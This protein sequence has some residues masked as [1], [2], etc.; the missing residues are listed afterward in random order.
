MHY[1]ARAGTESAPAA[2]FFVVLFMAFVVATVHG[3]QLFQSENTRTNETH[4][5]SDTDTGIIARIG[6][7]SISDDHY[8]NE[9]LRFYYR[10][11]Q[12]V[13]L[14]PQVRK[15]VVDSRVER[16]GIVSYAIENNWHERPEAL[17]RK[18]RIERKVKMETFE[19]LFIHNHVTV[20]DQDL[21]TL[22]G[23]LNT[24][25]RASHLFFRSNAMAWSAYYRLQDGE[26]FSDIAREAFQNAALAQNGGD[27]GYF[28]VDDMDIAFENTA[29]QLDIGEISQ[30]VKT[31]RGYSIIKLTDRI[32]TPVLT[33]AQFA[34]ARQ[35]L[36]PM[37]LDQKK[38]LATRNHMQTV[39]GSFAFDHDV[40]SALWNQFNSHRTELSGEVVTGERLLMRMQDRGEAAYLVNQDD[41]TLSA[42]DFWREFYYT[43]SEDRARVSH[44]DQFM[45]LVEGI[46]YRAYALNIVSLHG[47][48]DPDLVEATVQETFYD[49]LLGEFD[50]YVGRQVVIPEDQLQIEFYENRELYMD[51][52]ELNLSEIILTT[53]QEAERAWSELT[54]GT[55]FSDVLRTYTIDRDAVGYNG[56][57]GFISLPHFG[58][59]APSLSELQPGEIAGP[60]QISSHRYLIFFCNGRRESRLTTFEESKERVRAQLHSRGK[61]QLRSNIVDH[62]RS[63]FNAHVYVERMLSLPVEL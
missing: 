37:A 19:R 30:P 35:R 47:E 12:A 48:Y 10:T 55:P 22:F 4:G 2:R 49:Y 58:S 3:C 1:A 33:E 32:T 38:E 23:R 40:I 57:L 39:I 20:S 14:N 50:E 62:I 25:L 15:T 61:R 59:M 11:G 31:S 46:A 26:R 9:L 8:R 34:E 54:S 5:F 24:S 56:E 45:Q 7:F 43:P 29:Y 28:T 13:N 36:H 41:F 42:G 63:E 52:V 16:Y 44:K 6:D 60:F 53:A 21:R 18:A 27:I 51:P 17:Y